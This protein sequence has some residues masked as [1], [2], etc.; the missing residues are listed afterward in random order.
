MRSCDTDRLDGFDSHVRT[1]G[2]ADQLLHVDDVPIDVS[3]LGI[4][5]LPPGKRKQA[6]SQ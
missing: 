4:E 1:H 2:A 6:L 5:C 3:R